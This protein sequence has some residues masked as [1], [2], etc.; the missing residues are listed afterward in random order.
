MTEEEKAEL[1]LQE[2]SKKRK[3]SR[4]TASPILRASWKNPEN[5]NERAVEIDIEREIELFSKMYADNLQI[6][7]DRNE[8][9]SIWNRNFE[10]VKQE[11]ETYGYDTVLIIPENLPTEQEVSRKIIETMDEGAGKGKVNETLKHSNFIEGGS[12][13]GVRTSEKPKYRIILT[14]GD[15]NIYETPDPLL[16]ATLNKNINILTGLS[17]QEIA[18]RIQREDELPINFK[19]SIGGKEIEIMAEGM[20]LSEYM[21]FQR[22]NFE[23]TGKHLD[24]KGWTW[25]LKSFSGS[26]VVNSDWDPDARQLNVY[27]HDASHRNVDLGLR[28]SRSFS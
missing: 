7:I 3:E 21:I 28:L 4:E 5:Q 6:K 17:D 13:T 8:I 2:K 24:E 12:F 27:A 19:A 15:Q 10:S 9:I 11:I 22:A 16:K 23:K 20:S 18:Q 25:L 1:G 14:K 26:R